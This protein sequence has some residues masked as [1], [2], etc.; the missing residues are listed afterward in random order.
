MK[1]ILSLIIILFS[2]L[3]ANC[4]F[5]RYWITFTDKN[6]S[7]YSVSNPSAFLSQRAI[8]RRTNSSIPVTLQDLPVNPQYLDSVISKGAT[9]INKSRW[10]NGAVIN[11]PNGTVLNDIQNLSFVSSVTG[12]APLPKIENSN[13]LRVSKLIENNSAPNINPFSYDYGASLNQ[14]A[15]I[16]ADCLHNQGF[17][18]E[19]MLIAVLDAGFYGADTMAVFDSLRANNQIFSTY[20]FVANNSFVYDFSSHGSLVLSC[21]GGNFP[22][23]LVGTAPKANYIL[24]RTE[25]AATEYIIEEYNW[26]AG[27]EFA[28][29]CG[30]DVLNTS[31]GYKNFD[32]PSQNHLYSQLNGDV[33]PISIAHDIAASKG[34][35]VVCSAGNSG[36]AQIGAPADAD[37][38]LTVGAVD[39]NGAIASFSSVGPSAD[40]DIKPNVVAQGQATIVAW[41]GSGIMPG[42]GTSF[43]SPVMAGAVTCLWQANPTKTNM[44]IIAAVE[45]TGSQFLSPDSV[46]G[47]GIPDMCLANQLLNGV[48]EN[49]STG[50]ALG[51][52]FPNP[53]DD[54]FSITVIS[55]VPFVEIEMYDFAG[56]LISKE[57]F[58]IQANRA[59]Q[60]SITFPRNVKNG[61]Y[62]LRVNNIESVAGKMVVKY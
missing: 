61:M 46:Y 25:D 8:D 31:L 50:L 13:T 15:M 18:G 41:P 10:F 62:F 48:F 27:A 1:K 36:T 59:N 22:G 45:E 5:T 29:S 40:G 56:K 14:A 3:T 43:S 9:I 12:I 51:E 39:Q 23:S 16:G 4:Q 52:P 58:S 2:F 55:R 26:V 11:A 17:S 38:A 42:N 37:S 35:L 53:A 20:D 28:D 19:G 54:H 7:P 6:N 57:A 34:L 44:E 32:D 60:V 47:Y 30:A 33:A 24:L 21:M 49:A